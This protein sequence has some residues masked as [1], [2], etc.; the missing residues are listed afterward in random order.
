MD[1]LIVTTIGIGLIGLIYWF[2]FGKKEETMEASDTWNITV[3][4]GYK[5]RII[6]I[7]KDKPAT[8]TFTRKDPNSC[9]EEIVLPDYKIKK[10][11]PMNEPVT[12]TLPPPHPGKSG[13]H[14]GMNMYHGR[15]EVA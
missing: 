11:L 4:G 9:L 8:L 10:F 7:F 12:I 13:I 14:C 2:F 1:K 15:I 6:K 5:P 3:D